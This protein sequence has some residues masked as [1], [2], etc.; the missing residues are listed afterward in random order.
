MAEAIEIDFFAPFSYSIFKLDTSVRLVQ[1]RMKAN[2]TEIGE[3]TLANK[4]QVF[5]VIAW[6]LP[7]KGASIS[8]DRS[9][10]ARSCHHGCRSVTKNCYQWSQ[11]AIQTMISIRIVPE[12][13]SYY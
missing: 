13:T 6:T 11:R 7:K 1:D 12:R 4:V 5:K 9:S 10:V 3:T 2:L 8:S